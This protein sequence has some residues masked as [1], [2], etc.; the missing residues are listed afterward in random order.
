MTGV[1]ALAVDKRERTCISQPRYVLTSARY[2]AR[3]SKYCGF[4]E[5]RL[6]ESNNPMQSPSRAFLQV[7]GTNAAAL[8]LG[9]RLLFGAESKRRLSSTTGRGAKAAQYVQVS[10]PCTVVTT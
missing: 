2:H 9:Y 7:S 1:G 3:N 8:S 5:A 6:N 10:D 4:G